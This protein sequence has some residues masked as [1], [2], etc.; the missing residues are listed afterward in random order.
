MSALSVAAPRISWPPIVERA[1]AIA[2]SYS[3]SVTLRQVFYRLVSEH[4]LPNSDS[5]YKTLSARTAEARREGWFPALLDQG[6]QVQRPYWR[7]DPVGALQSLARNYRRDRTEGQEVQLWVVL[8][9][10]T[11]LEQVVQ[12]TEDYGIP[13]VA[14]RG[15]GSQTIKDDVRDEVEGDGRPAIA[16]YLGDLD[17]SG[18]DIQRDFEERTDFCFDELHRLAVTFE[19]I[20]ELGLVPAPGKRTDSRA[21]GFIAKY[22]QLVQVEVEAIDPRVLEELVTDAAF[23]YIDEDV[24]G[25]VLE[26]EERE[27]EILRTAAVDMA[28]LV[29]EADA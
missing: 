10:A 6:R 22:G 16:L 7:D 8:E 27:R 9:K 17:P 2:G 5:S 23:D 25:Q 4:L 14:A 24:H 13:V 1:A 19:Q 18:E 20:D 12:W 15:Y 21:P 29:G 28:R 3:T 11:L 26:R